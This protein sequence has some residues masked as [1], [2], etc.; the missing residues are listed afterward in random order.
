MKRSVPALGSFALSLLVAA[1]SSDG[2]EGP[3]PF[4]TS[5]ES[6][7]E[8]ELGA[9]F[10]VDYVKGDAFVASPLGRTRV[11]ARDHDGALAAAKKLFAEHGKAFG[12]G[13]SPPSL[14]ES[15]AE[16]S[17]TVI[18]LVQRIPGTEIEVQGKGAILDL[19]TDGTMLEAI[20]ALADVPALTRPVTTTAADVEAKVASIAKAMRLPEASPPEIVG[21]PRLVATENGGERE[22]VWLT[23]FKIDLQGF[24][25][26]LDAYTLDI[27]E[28]T[29]PRAGL[30][31]AAVPSA[32]AKGMFSYPLAQ[33]V[34][35]SAKRDLLPIETTLKDGKYYLVRNGSASTSEVATKECTSVSAAERTP[36]SV[37]ISSATNDEF[38]GQYLAL[39]F[40]VNGVGLLGPGIA[41]DVHHNALQVD[42]HFRALFSGEGPSADGK[43][44]GLIHAN[45]KFVFH[46]G[47]PATFE[48]DGGRHSASW[49]PVTN[50]V[51]FGD[52]G[53][54]EPIGAWV[55][56]PG[57]A[58]DITAHE[59]THA[60]VT[61]K[62]KLGLVGEDGAMQEGIADAIGVFVAARAGQRDFTGIGK[63]VRLD[64]KYVRN[65][66]DPT[67]TNAPSTASAE[68]DNTGKRLTSLP[69]PKMRGKMDKACAFRGPDQ[70]CV[71]FNAGPLNHAFYLMVHGGG[72]LFFNRGNVAHSVRVIPGNLANIEKVWVASAR[73]APN[74][75]PAEPVRGEV[76]FMRI[77]AMALQQVNY[78][79]SLG[80]S[81]TTAAVGCAWLGTDF[82]TREQLAVRGV[83]CLSDDT[84]RAAEGPSDCRGKSDGYH[85]N[86][87]SP[88]SGTLC[89]GGSIAGGMQCRSGMICARKSPGS[90]EARMTAEGAL[91][92]EEPQ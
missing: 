17:S 50:L 6:Q 47:G 73:T 29:S 32:P 19:D 8:A 78:A 87:A 81:K 38:L 9:K 43:L 20:G 33:L 42:K 64:G 5:L 66:A 22:I 67:G 45:D 26:K 25:A 69:M 54:L 88:F 57:V 59:W 92:C 51:S 60:Y 80:D 46:T 68:P 53:Y 11:V 76:S 71:H 18:H 55:K 56:P 13:Q 63:T 61:R 36:K 24:E 79:R 41:V 91:E 7:L 62:A 83:T 3:A 90:T 84:E 23:T 30:E 49:D 48:A 10:S 2:A 28:V 82:V 21:T 85:C 77:E 35:P 12:S 40:K 65:F 39:G 70:G 72:G 44:V 86:S 75:G 14:K 15:D 37:D 16:P 1:C 74:V 27:R 58:L 4:E 31:G 34:D 52:G 89:R